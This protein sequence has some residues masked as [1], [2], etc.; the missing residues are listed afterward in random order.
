MNFGRRSSERLLTAIPLAA[1]AL[2]IVGLVMAVRP[3]DASTAQ[4][5][6]LMKREAEARAETAR[7]KGRLSESSALVKALTWVGEAEQ[8]E[9]E[10]ARRV[11]ALARESGLKM[12]AFRPQRPTESGG[13]IQQP[14]VISLEGRFP[15]VVRFAARLGT[16]ETRLPV[17]VLQ[18]ASSDAATDSVT[19]SVEVVALRESTDVTGNKTK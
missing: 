18:V 8:I 17:T 12:V 3:K 6:D 15:A 11:T 7:L 16:P 5:S 4:S 9:T 1:A 14:Y 13:L 10:A 2:F 19:A